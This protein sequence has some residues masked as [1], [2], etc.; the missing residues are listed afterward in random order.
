MSAPLPP[1][2]LHAP[3]TTR[4]R[5]PILQVLQSVL[6]ERGVVLEI[7]SGT[8]E[9]ASFFAR[10]LPGL[11]WQPSDRDA[12]CRVSIAAHAAAAGAGN[13]LPALN[14]DVAASGWAQ[15]VADRHASVDA[16]LCVN[17]VHVTAWTTVGPMMARV[18]QQLG[19]AGHHRAD[20]RPGGHMDQVDAQGRVDRSVPVGNV[21]RPPR[22]GHV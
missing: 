16:A 20:R 5:A 14:L 9:H 17:L 1:G 8:G 22:R 7:A 4:N 18:A 15:D 12:D 2:A 10:A 19:D 13:V 11:V 21:L 6:P 3:A